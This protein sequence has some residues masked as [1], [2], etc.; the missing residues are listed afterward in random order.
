V[1]RAFWLETTRRQDDLVFFL[2]DRP[3]PRGTGE[4]GGQST[5]A[6]IALRA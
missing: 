5:S 3:P 1:R 6:K 2:I 4:R